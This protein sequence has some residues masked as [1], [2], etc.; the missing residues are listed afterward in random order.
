MLAVCAVQRGRGPSTTVEFPSIFGYLCFRSPFGP[1]LGSAE[2]ALAIKYG[3]PP[4]EGAGRV[5]LTRAERGK[6][7]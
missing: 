5:K 6:E 2:C 4:E 7:G 3:G 1:L